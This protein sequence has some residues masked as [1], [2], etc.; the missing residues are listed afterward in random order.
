VQTSGENSVPDTFSDDFSG[1][2]TSPGADSP[3]QNS[4]AGRRQSTVGSPPY[5]AAPDLTGSSVGGSP[6]A[7]LMCTPGADVFSTRG[8]TMPAPT[9]L[10]GAAVPRSDPATESSVAVSSSTSSATGSVA[11]ANDSGGSCSDGSC[12][13]GL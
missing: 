12:C 11:S 9:L 7:P 4:S 6:G 2:D 13:S 3:A 1:N 8:G 10:P 5:V